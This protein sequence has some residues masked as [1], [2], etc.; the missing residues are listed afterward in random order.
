MHE[1][2]GI[3]SI[4]LD[5]DQH[6]DR[7]SF[8]VKHDCSAVS[9]ISK[10]TIIPVHPPPHRITDSQVPYPIIRGDR[11]KHAL[12]FAGLGADLAH[13]KGRLVI[14][15]PKIPCAPNA[16]TGRVIRAL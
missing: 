10:R 4:M 13:S 15:S 12:G 16:A 11:A 14:H 3:V 5:G 2:R 8:V 6:A 1:R 7:V 9:S